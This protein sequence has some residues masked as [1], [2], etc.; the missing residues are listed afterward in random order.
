[1]FELYDYKRSIRSSSDSWAMSSGGSV[2]DVLGG[3]VS[4]SVGPFLPEL[5]VV[6]HV[7]GSSSSLD[8]GLH[9]S[10]IDLAIAVS[11]DRAPLFFE[12]LNS[13]SAGL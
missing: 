10:P 11:I 2:P 6:L 8:P 9:L 7:L 13:V 12:S 3:D 4:L 5:V 1:M